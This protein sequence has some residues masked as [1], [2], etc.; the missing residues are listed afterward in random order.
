MGISVTMRIGIIENLWKKM[1]TLQIPD[2]QKTI[3][4]S[5]Q[6][7]EFLSDKGITFEH[8]ETP[9]QLT[10]ESSQEEVLSAYNHVLKP[11]MEE[12]GYETADVV[13]IHSGIDNYPAIRQKFLAEHTHSDDEV[14][15]FVG[16]KALFWFNL[17]GCY[18]FNVLCEA[19][20]LISVPEGT[21]HW[22]DAGEK[23]DVKAV[24]LFSNTEGWVP[25]YTDSKIE[26]KYQNISIS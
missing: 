10:N 26:D 15:F 12:N 11:Y 18:I 1:T 2:I 6:I 20:D 22:F 21:K 8:W 19:G 3:T 13:N 25:N 9:V 16:G 5:S 24:R 7:K 4:E 14:R 23:P 17:D